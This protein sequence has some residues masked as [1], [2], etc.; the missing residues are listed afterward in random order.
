MVDKLGPE[1]AEPVFERRHRRRRV[2]RVLDRPGGSARQGRGR[3][4]FG[5]RLSGSPAT[6]GGARPRRRISS[7]GVRRRARGSGDFLRARR[8]ERGDRFGGGS[9]AEAGRHRVRRG[10]REIG[11][12][13]RDRAPS[14]GACPSGSRAS[15]RRNGTIGP[16]GGICDVVREPVVHIDAARKGL[17]PKRSRSSVGS[18]RRWDPISK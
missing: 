8:R 7:D 3:D 17:R 10:L 14:A 16:G 5:R 4:R 9:H 18:G 13:R 2:D 11:R 12:D 15:R 1:L 6:R